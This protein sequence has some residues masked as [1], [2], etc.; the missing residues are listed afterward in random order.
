[1]FSVVTGFTIAALVLNLVS[2]FIVKV[3][4]FLSRADFSVQ[5]GIGP[6]P[7]IFI[8]EIMTVLIRV[9]SCNAC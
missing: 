3:C 4:C 6:S 7:I 5:V 2:I 1:M 8:F 9:D